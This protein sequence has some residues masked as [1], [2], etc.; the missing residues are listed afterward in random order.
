MVTSSEDEEAVEGYVEQECSSPSRGI[1]RVFCEAKS[2]K[3]SVSP[4]NPKYSSREQTFVVGCGM[5]LSFNSGFS[6]GL[7]LSGLLTPPDADVRTQGTS[8]Y[9]GVT[10][11]SALALA[12]LAVGGSPQYRQ[13][14]RVSNLTYF[15]FQTTMI[16]AFVVGSMISGLLNPRPSPWRLAPKYAPTFFLCTAFMSIAAAL[17]SLDDTILTNDTRTRCFYFVALANGIQNGISSMYSANLIRTTH[18]SGALTYIGPAP[19]SEFHQRVEASHPSWSDCFV[20]VWGLRFDV[21]WPCVEVARTSI[22]CLHLPIPIYTHCGIPRAHLAR[23]MAPCLAWNVA[24]ATD[25]PPTQHLVPRRR[26]T[27]TGRSVGQPLCRHGLGRRRLHW[28]G[29]IA[30]WFG[31]SRVHRLVPLRPPRH[32]PRVRPKRRQPNGPIR[33]VRLGA[34]REPT[35]EVERWLCTVDLLMT[36]S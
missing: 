22:Q 12:S 14:E 2:Q 31:T 6:N 25:P 27:Q 15:G 1:G 21:R 35:R 33:L 7:A 11:H 19:A 10:T 24:L 4:L 29:R 17:S 9:S 20:L 5:L 26:F 36:S 8:G 16:L 13:N 30:Q 32:V 34:R 28:G 18:V 3:V 23:A